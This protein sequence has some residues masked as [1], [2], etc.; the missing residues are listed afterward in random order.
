MPSPVRGLAL[1]W[2]G[3]SW[4]G[5]GAAPLSNL[6]RRASLAR[7]RPELPGPR[8]SNLT[9][10]A[11]S[12]RPSVSVAGGGGRDIGSDGPGPIQPGPA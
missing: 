6:L 8:R 3:G 11:V 4:R 9:Y 7:H 5:L 12:D 1:N 2:A 10:S